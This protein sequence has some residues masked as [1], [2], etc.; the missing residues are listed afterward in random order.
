VAK[1]N[2]IFT[3]RG[4]SCEV[5]DRRPYIRWTADE[6]R[7]KKPTS[8]VRV[9]YRGLTAEQ[10]TA[11]SNVARQCDGYVMVRHAPP[12]LGLPHVYPELRPDGEVET[13]RPV[14]HWH[15]NDWEKRPA[16]KE[17]VREYDEW[18]NRPKNAYELPKKHIHKAEHMRRSGHIDK[19]KFL[20][21]HKGRNNGRIHSHADK[22]KYVFPPSGKRERKWEHD[23]VESYR[24]AKKRE[25]HVKK[26]HDGKDLPDKHEHSRKVKNDSENLARRLDMHPMAVERFAKARR[27]FFVI[28]GCLKADAVLS[29]GEAVF[30]V[31][32]VTLWDA[33]ELKEFG[34]RYLRGKQVIIVPD[35]DWHEKW[36]LVE[37]AMLCKM[38]L[39]RRGIEAHV[40]APPIDARGNPVDGLKGVDDFLGAG[41][42]VDELHVIERRMPLFLTTWEDM[43]DG[44]RDRLKRDAH[45]LHALALHAD[46]QGRVH[47]SFR[48][49]ARVMDIPDMS[50]SRAIKD[51]AENF[52]AVTV[53][54]DLSTRRDYFSRQE[55]WQKEG[56]VIILNPELRCSELPPLPLA[57][58]KVPGDEVLH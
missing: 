48:K 34:E 4:V 41:H 12:G 57:E 18:K 6:E 39:V 14:R 32:S 38:F 1:S 44:R 26:W 43:H 45:V 16:E 50:V 20:D 17:W 13:K 9:A 37:Q 47:T 51:L 40:A 19:A 29:V 5:R 7:R 46:P 28:E 52:G 53:E 21:D 2:D 8:P 49:I 10:K 58:L 55:R 3:E 35:A 31:P 22:A 27:V 23:H 33:P 54:G 42:R 56:P 25:E 11:M 15:G 24:S 36:Q 30:S